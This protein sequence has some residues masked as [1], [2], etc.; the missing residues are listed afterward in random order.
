V[1]REDYLLIDRSLLWQSGSLPDG[2]LVGRAERF[3]EGYVEALVGGV[4]PEPSLVG[5]VLGVGMMGRR[6]RR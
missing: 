1:D 6:G 2:M 3:G 5:V 4:V